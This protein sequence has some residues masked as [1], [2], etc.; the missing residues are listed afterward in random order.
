MIIEGLCTTLNPDGG[1]NVAPMG[2]IIEDNFAR[3]RLR[4]FPTST[5]YANLKRTLRGVFHVTDDVLL[6][7]R[8]AIDRIPAPPA[9]RPAETID[10]AVLVD[11]C[12]WYEFECEPLDESGERPL[13][14]AHV[15]HRGRV[16]DFVGFNRARHAVI[17]AAIL[18]SRLHLL[19]REFILNEMAKLRS[20]VEK[21]G[22]EPEREAF[23]LLES[24]LRVQWH[25]EQA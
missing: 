7:A 8:A 9:T 5:T 2:P 4:P 17:E 23:A 19:E 3:L 16:R 25:E 20:A 22:D 12:R 24:T 1:V 21:T 14:V 15:K 18:V 6:L 13:F 11:C 10:G